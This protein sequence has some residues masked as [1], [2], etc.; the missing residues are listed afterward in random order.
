METT[1][2]KILLVDDDPLILHA[3]KR[4]LR[5]RF[6]VDIAENAEDALFL[7]SGRGPYAA[8]LSDLVMAGIDGVE[9]LSALAELA[10]VTARIALSGCIDSRTEEALNRGRAYRVLSKPCHLEELIETIHQAISARTGAGALDR[11]MAS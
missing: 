9:L 5:R 3:L 11:R 6:E 7:V 4:C 8:V 10:P 1:R 2:P